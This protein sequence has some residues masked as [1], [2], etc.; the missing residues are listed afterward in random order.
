MARV[1]ATSPTR[2]V[3]ATV[4]DNLL[5]REG[6]DNGS[7][8]SGQGGAVFDKTPPRARKISTQ[9]IVISS[10]TA[11]FPGV[12]VIEGWAVTVGL[13]Y[14][15]PHGFCYDIGRVGGGGAHAR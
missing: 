4:F 6:L 5:T 15:S 3:V 2:L 11:D 10:A 8:G 1:T 14:I 9:Q 12:D 13:C 7:F